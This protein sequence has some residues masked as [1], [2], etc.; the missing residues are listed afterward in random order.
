[1]LRCFKILTIASILIIPFSLNAGEI[2]DP[3]FK[4]AYA[5]SWAP[6]SVGSM[7]SVSGILPALMDEIIHNQMDITIEHRG[8][9]WARAQRA[10]KT[11]E[12][13]AFITTPTQERLAFA[14]ASEGIVFP[15]RFQP[16]VRLGSEEEK[17]LKS[18]ADITNILSDKRYCDVLGNGWAK[19]FFDEKGI[20][21]QVVP[22]LDICLKHLIHNQIDIIIHATPVA[23]SF[24]RKLNVSDKVTILPI[25]MSSS[26]KFPLLVSKNSPYGVK[27]LEEFDEV[28]LKIKN[29]GVWETL[30][31]TSNTATN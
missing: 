15:L 5:E 7:E 2:N 31:R 26:P 3:V 14:R 12:V 13:D 22:T 18:E 28:L 17:L 21:F 24:I 19:R 4:V 10:V 30:L 23:D 16:I 29:H 9:P 27:F 25:V 6:I 8:L 20:S 1:M 11:G